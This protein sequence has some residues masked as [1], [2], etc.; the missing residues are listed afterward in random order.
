MTQAALRRM[1]VGE[2]SRPMLARHARLRFDDTRER[3]VLLVPERVLAPDDIAIAILQLCDGSRDVAAVIDLLAGK[4]TAPREV[5]ANDVIALLQDL[6]GKGF[7]VNA[8][9]KVQ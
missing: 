8:R 9:E 2:S 4:Y 1:E 5:I 3:W 7:I 6:A